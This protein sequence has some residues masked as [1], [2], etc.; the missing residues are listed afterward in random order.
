M[1]L[2]TAELLDTAQFPKMPGASGHTALEKY[3]AAFLRRTYAPTEERTRMR[4]W[5]SVNRCIA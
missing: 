4:C 5:Q 3:R 1:R 2:E